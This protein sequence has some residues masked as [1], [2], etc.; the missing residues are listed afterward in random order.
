MLAFVFA[1]DT[2]RG[3][4]GWE[5]ALASAVAVLV[6]LLTLIFLFAFFL[7]I[8]RGSLMEETLRRWIEDLRPLPDTVAGVIDEF[9]ARRYEFLTFYGQFI[10]TALVV[11][12]I[13]L[14]LLAG[15]VESDAGLPIL[16]TVLGIILGKTVLTRRAL[17][18]RPPIEEEP[19]LEVGD[20][21][22]AEEDQ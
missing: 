1:Q 4:R 17:P 2:A 16:A 11:A 8:G 15:V 13:T 22:F 5:L 14:L 19:E 7:Q 18:E 10:L 12:S 20:D 21:E 9:I 6:T 3:L